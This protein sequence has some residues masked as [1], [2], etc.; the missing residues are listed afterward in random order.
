MK[1]NQKFHLAKKRIHHVFLVP[2]D[3]QPLP[4][5]IHAIK[6]ADYILIGPGSLYTSI[7]PN[8]LVK[9]IGD[10]VVRAKGHKIYICNL[11]TQKG[12]TIAY[13]AGDHVKA[14]H[15]HV[16]ENFIDAILVNDEKLPHPCKRVI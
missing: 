13:T 7:I 9:E 10:A 4:E 5:A 11:M 15:D 12:E 8:L 14:I 16:G 6:R 1:V 3:L 2:D